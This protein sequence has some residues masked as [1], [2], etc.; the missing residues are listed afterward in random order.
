MPTELLYRIID[1]PKG[2]PWRAWVV[3]PFW[4][5]IALT[6]GGVWVGAPWFIFNSVAMGS[7]TR[8]REILAAALLPVLI[9][10]SFLS[11]YS[12]AKLIELPEVGF[13]YLVLPALVVKMVIGYFLF[14]VQSR[15]F[16]LHE[17]FGQPAR[18]GAIVAVAAFLL[19]DRVLE[20]MHPLV[21]LMLR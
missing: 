2:S 5:W 1:E 19:H 7:P 13:K 18:N 15:A 4:P 16:Q 3:K 8:K 10:G 9:L 14:I 21:R 17:H 6:L 20:S 11:L 12:G